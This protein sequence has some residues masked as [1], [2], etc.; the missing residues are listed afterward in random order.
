MPHDKTSMLRT[1]FNHLITKVVQWKTVF[2]NW[3]LGTRDE[4][5]GAFKAIQDAK[6]DNIRT[7]VKLDGLIGLLMERGLIN[8]ADLLQEQ[9]EVANRL[10]LT[11]EAKFPGAVATDDGMTYDEARFQDTKNK[12]GFPL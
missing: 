8:E 9:I 11:L 6:D 2:A 5:D 7:N 12:L 10:E 4:T 1:Q 3:Q